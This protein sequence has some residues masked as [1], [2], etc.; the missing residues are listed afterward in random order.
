VPDLAEKYGAEYHECLAALGVD[1]IDQFPKAS[2]H[3][4][5]IIE[6]CQKLIASGFAY[7]SDGNVWFDVAKDPD[8]G[9]L[10]HRKPEDQEAGT[11]ELA[12]SGKRS[13]A[14]FALW[15]AAKKGEPQWD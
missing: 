5:E 8:Y 10:S 15:K 13:P 14:D 7:V 6:L 3:M 1:S 12:G 4:N 2:Q 9:K 11:R